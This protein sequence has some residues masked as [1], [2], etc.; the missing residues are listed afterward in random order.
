MS[1]RVFELW[2]PGVPRP[3]G[4]LQIVT[5]KSTGQAFAK[6]SPKLI[7]YRNFAV[8]EYVKAWAGAPPLDE[9]LRLA[10]VFYLARAKSH[11]G[12]GKNSKKIKPSAPAWPQGMPDLDKLLRTQGDALTIAR[13]ISDDALIVE[14]AA[15]KRWEG[16]RGPGVHV[17]LSTLR[18]G[19]TP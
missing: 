3:Q 19:G 11:Y 14:L 4:S 16:Y 17:G 9:P 13:V 7:D 1:S 2:I 15:R 6:N 5:S 8:H 18:V 10:V 12:T